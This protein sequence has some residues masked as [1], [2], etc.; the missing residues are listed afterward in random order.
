MIM[1][2]KEKMVALI[3][4]ETPHFKWLFVALNPLIILMNFYLEILLLVVADSHGL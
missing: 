4:K 1:F 2:T 3:R